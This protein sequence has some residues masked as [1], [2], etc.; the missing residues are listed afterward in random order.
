MGKGGSDEVYDTLVRAMREPE[1]VNWRSQ[2]TPERADQY[3]AE[4]EQLERELDDGWPG[5]RRKEPWTQVTPDKAAWIKHRLKRRDLIVRGRGAWGVRIMWRGETA[6]LMREASQWTKLSGVTRPFIGGFRRITAQTGLTA[7]IYEQVAFTSTFGDPTALYL[8][9]S[10]VSENFVC[11]RKGSYLFTGNLAIAGTTI[12]GAGVAIA[13]VKNST[14]PGIEPCAF[15]NDIVGVGAARFMGSVS[16]V[17]E[18]DAADAIGLVGNIGSG[19]S[20]QFEY[21]ATIAPSLTYAEQ[22]TW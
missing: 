6:L 11:P 2:Y 8:P 7:G 17:F 22:V 5:W 21:G 3:T 14:T 9:Y 15:V 20:L 12:A 18:L 16:G 13:I 1:P 10:S 19:T 4:L